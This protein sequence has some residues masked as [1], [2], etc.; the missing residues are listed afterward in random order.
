MSEENKAIVQRFFEEVWNEGNSQVADEII[1]GAY[2]QTDFTMGFRRIGG[3]DILKIEVDAYR[4]VTDNLHFEVEEIIA[5]GDK[6]V[7]RWEATAMPRG[8]DPSNTHLQS[9]AS[10]VTIN[11]IADGKITDIILYSL[12]GNTGPAWLP[13]VQ[14]S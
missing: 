11:H 9:R 8:E 4:S 1:D 5:E 7:A 6:V 14:P 12:A 13:G 3:S 2:R 10:G